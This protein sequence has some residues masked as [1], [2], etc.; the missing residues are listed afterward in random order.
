[1]V[2]SVSPFEKMFENS[3]TY[4]IQKHNFNLNT[5][6]EIFTINMINMIKSQFDFFLYI[7]YLNNT[8]MCHVVQY[9]RKQE[10]MY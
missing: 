4:F 9:S 6:S 8:C 7:L 5:K 3:A 1:M 10:P 2:N